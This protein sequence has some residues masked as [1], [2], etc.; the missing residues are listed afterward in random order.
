MSAA[1]AVGAT[2]K[3]SMPTYDWEK[4]EANFHDDPGLH[5]LLSLTTFRSY[6]NPR[7]LAMLYYGGRAFLIYST[8][9]CAGTGYTLGQIEMTASD[10]LSASSCLAQTGTTN[11]VTTGS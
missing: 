1:G 2:T 10:P 11:R 7:R 9:N 3:I 5:A 8:L 4:V 6:A